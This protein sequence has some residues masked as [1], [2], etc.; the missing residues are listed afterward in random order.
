ML[1][2]LAVAKNTALASSSR[3]PDAVHGITSHPLT[4]LLLT[5]KPSERC[6]DTPGDELDFYDLTRGQH[7]DSGNGN[8]YNA[9]SD[10]QSN[11]DI[12]TTLAAGE[13]AS[14]WTAFDVPSRHG[15]IVYSPNTDGQPIAEWSY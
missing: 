13:M 3:P 14:G 12:T 8:A 4:G 2:E 15:T 10:R 5:E 11:A 1:G 7:H 9:L 6:C